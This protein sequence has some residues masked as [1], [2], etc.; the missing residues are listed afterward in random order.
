[1]TN[2][3]SNQQGRVNLGNKSIAYEKKLS[4]MRTELTLLLF[5]TMVS[6]LCSPIILSG[7]S[8]ECVL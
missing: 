1:M 6:I 3:C 4:K 5:M 2:T 8:G 7:F